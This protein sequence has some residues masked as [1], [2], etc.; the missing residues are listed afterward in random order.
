[1]RVTIDLMKSSTQIIDLSSVVN[2]RVGDDDLQLP[3]HIG[4]GDSLV[5]MRG[6]DVEFLSQD[7]SNNNIYI[8][9]TVNT[10]TPGDNLFMG[11]LTFRFP[12]GTFKTDGTYDP[13]KTM[14]RIV[15]KETQKVISS[16]NVKITVMKNSIEFNFDP[17][18]TSYDSRLET[19]LND[20]HDKGQTML[21]AIKN[22]NDQANSN[23]SG[24]TA[25][26]ANEAKQ[27]AKAN[28]GDISDLKGEVTGA[29]GRFS[30]LPGR[31]DAQDTAIS[32]KETI[33]NANANY[34][35]LQQKDAQQDAELT[36][37]AGKFELEDKLAQMSLVPEAF[38]NETALKAK[39]PNGKEGIMVTADTG[40]KYIWSNNAWTDAGVYQSAGIAKGAVK[41]DNLDDQSKI[42]QSVFFDIRKSAL[43]RGYYQYLPFSYEIG[44]VDSSTGN[45][46]DNANM[47]RTGFVQG[48]GKTWTFWNSNPDL[49]NYRLLSYQ[50]DGT[51]KQL[52][53]DWISSDGAKFTSDASL[54]YRLTLVTKNQ[55]AASVLDGINAVRVTSDIDLAPYNP[56]KISNHGNL[57]ITSPGVPEKVVTD[58][59]TFSVSIT[60]PTT[61][62][63][64][65]N[66]YNELISTLDKSY[67]GQSFIVPNNS[68]LYWDITDNKIL[69]LSS[70]QVANHNLQLL[71]Y[72]SYT[73]ITSGLF[74]NYF[75]MQS[76]M[77]D[78]L[79][80]IG[81]VDLKP[82]FSV[83][84]KHVVT[85]TL[86]TSNTL[87]IT[88]YDGTDTVQIK[89][90]GQS[91]VLNPSDCL[92]CNITTKQLEIQHD[93]YVRT[94]KVMLAYNS[95]GQITSGYFSR[96]WFEHVAQKQ[97]DALSTGGQNQPNDYY[98][99]YMNAKVSQIQQAE[100]NYS[101]G[102]QFIFITD[103][104]WADNS[105]QSPL[106]I[107]QIKK[108]TGVRKVV[109]GGDLPIAYG[110]KETMDNQIYDFNKSL[111]EYKR[112]R[113]Y[114]PI[115]GN[116][117]FTTR[118]S[119]TSN[120][121]FTYSAQKS[122]GLI[123][124]DLED[125]TNIKS[126]KIYYYKDNTAQKIRYV[127]VNTEESVDDTTFWGVNANISQEQADWLVNDALQAPDGYQIVVFGHVP[128]EESL[129]D[130]NYKLDIL[131]KILEAV[132][133]KSVIN[134]NS[135]YGAVVNH[136]FSN[137]KV[138]VIAYI[139]GHCH[140]DRSVKTNGLLHITTGCDAHYN[141]DTWTR[142]VGTTSE[143]LF[144]VFFVDT[145]NSKINTIRIGA[146]NDRNFDY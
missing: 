31:E 38:E 109:F 21:D 72:N 107:E 90:T 129:P 75:K 144:D 27:Q 96:F 24:D 80:V 35:A 36:Q 128:I 7:T 102:D 69:V 17:D 26:I 86:P 43:N 127:F 118:A 121:G 9:G 40:H 76:K 134:M 145:V 13:D 10:N 100:L 41:Y 64:Y 137:S 5:D 23:V 138:K 105:K 117:D 126:G 47:L 132:N 140:K 33:V 45:D 143:Q 95:W 20:F 85:I 131:R 84:D 77:T 114:Y 101:N 71:A 92:V 124:R 112:E 52:E 73:N 94:N 19:M 4:Y 46:R 34:T 54:S 49:Y 122:Y 8:A 68:A 67:L 142:T 104:H 97:I 56:M 16:V 111:R 146:G 98:E 61:S 139:A 32:Q 48:D 53:F 39:Y 116:H 70:N 108:N 89:M 22:L 12:A 18:K 29:R 93:G 15:D 78:Y 110:T 115:I 133:N 58:A 30:D 119:A 103:V 106:L 83:N 3:L 2:P 60:I 81:G 74:E 44:A 37:K 57:I 88:N 50:L 1:M 55:S 87:Y 14:F 99:D 82:T 59:N 91:F 42:S 141:D 11:D 135:G 66:Q 6:K 125:Y 63:F 62:V 130:Y 79:V 123:G 120:D 113:D 65:L 28:A 25:T 136:D 51:F